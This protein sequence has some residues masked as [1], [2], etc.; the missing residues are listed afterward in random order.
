MNS[1][2]GY[3][4]PPDRFNEEDPTWALDNEGGYLAEGDGS[5]RFGLRDILLVGVV[6]STAGSIMPLLQFKRTD[7]F[8]AEPRDSDMPRILRLD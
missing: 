7:L 1:R 2:I 4:D 3:Q 8:P 5:K 6:Q